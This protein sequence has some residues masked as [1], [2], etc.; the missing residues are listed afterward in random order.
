MHVRTLA[1]VSAAWFILAVCL[2]L[3]IAHPPS[4][5]AGGAAAAPE[6]YVG[7]AKIN[8]IR[9]RQRAEREAE[10]AKAAREPVGRV[11]GVPYY[12]VESYVSA[13]E[14]YE[15]GKSSAQKARDY[16]DKVV[17]GPDMRVHRADRIT[18]PKDNINNDAPSSGSKIIHTD[19]NG[20]P[21]Y[22]KAPPPPPVSWDDIERER[23]KI[24]QERIKQLRDKARIQGTRPPVPP[25]PPF[26]PFPVGAPPVWGNAPG[27]S[28][29]RPPAPQLP[30]PVGP[31]VLGAPPRSGNAPRPPMPTGPMNVRPPASTHGY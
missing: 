3:L 8:S 4:L 10:S 18:G 5:Y 25:P 28:V 26:V 31:G 2:S 27:P 21:I 22:P 9:E 1:G 30:P 15:K 29:A 23:S 16:L 17:N 19:W 6:E 24:N 20:N 14:K 13:V 11:N 7:N 12:T